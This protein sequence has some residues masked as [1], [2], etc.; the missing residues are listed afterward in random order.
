MWKSYRWGFHSRQE[1]A[2]KNRFGRIGVH[3]IL[4]CLR[5]FIRNYEYCSTLIVIWVS[6]DVGKETAQSL[7]VYD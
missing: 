7:A 3:L 6:C 1:V 2:A 5:V 4:R